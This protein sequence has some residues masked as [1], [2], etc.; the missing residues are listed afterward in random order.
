MAPDTEPD[1]A[2]IEYLNLLRW[3]LAGKENNLSMKEKYRC[4]R[5][6]NHHICRILK[7]TDPIRFNDELAKQAAEC[8]ISDNYLWIM[9]KTP[10]KLFIMLENYPLSSK[11]ILQNEGKD[12]LKEFGSPIIASCNKASLIRKKI[13]IT[14]AREFANKVVAKSDHSLSRHNRDNYLGYGKYDSG[15]WIARFVIRTENITRE[16]IIL[17]NNILE[18]ISYQDVQWYEIYLDGNLIQQDEDTIPVGVLIY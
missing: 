18:K 4:N 2:I 12:Y 13:N 8:G 6:I 5:W 9:K 10:K 1:R 16:I 11:E 14:Y 17:N 7:L 15:S 3:K